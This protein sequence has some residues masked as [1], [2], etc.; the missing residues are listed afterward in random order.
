MTLQKEKNASIALNRNNVIV[1]IARLQR[2]NEMDLG[3]AVIQLKLIVPTRKHQCF[4][5]QK[6]VL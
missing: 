3:N 5:D 6:R 2:M 1:N 4:A